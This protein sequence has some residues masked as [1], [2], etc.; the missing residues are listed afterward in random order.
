MHVFCMHVVVWS[1]SFSCLWRRRRGMRAD[2]DSPKPSRPLWTR[3]TNPE[4]PRG[5]AN[6]ISHP[7]RTLLPQTQRRGDKAQQ[8]VHVLIAN[9]PAEK[10]TRHVPEVSWSHSSVIFRPRVITFR[11]TSTR[12]YTQTFYFFLFDS[13]CGFV[14]AQFFEY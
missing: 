12:E 14:V 3:Q 7:V 8:F 10:E 6:L 5:S 9:P 11:E 4:G 13:I 1:G 2:I